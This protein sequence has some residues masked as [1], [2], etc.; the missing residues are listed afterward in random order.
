MEWGKGGSGCSMASV[1]EGRLL[2]GLGWS[3][4]REEAPRLKK[5]EVGSHPT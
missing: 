5:P 2:P 3:V 4:E 1:A